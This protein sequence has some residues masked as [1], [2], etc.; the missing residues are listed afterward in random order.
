MHTQN[1]W[2]DEWNQWQA[3]S[4]SLE[5]MRQACTERSRSIVQEVTPIIDDDWELEQYARRHHLTINE[6]VYYFNAYEYGGDDGL[7]AIRNP[8]IIPPEVAR[9]A[10]KTIDNTLQ[11]YSPLRLTDEGTGLGVYQ[12]QQRTN[13]DRYLFPVC[14]LRLTLKS[15]KWHLYWMRKFDAWWPYPPP[16]SDQRFTLQARLQQVLADED[17]CFWG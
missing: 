12:I 9:Q 3:S 2:S 7:E 17:G 13:G 5:T 6:I 14:Q 1:A 16:Q 15:H 10:L 4:R 8:D 11:N